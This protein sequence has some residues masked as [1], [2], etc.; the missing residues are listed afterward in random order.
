M[1]KKI[2]HIMKIKGISG[3]E[4]HLM[5]LLPCLSKYYDVSMVML[6]EN[7]FVFDFRPEVPVTRV[8]IKSHYD[9]SVIWRLY[10]V[11][12]GLKPDIVHTHLIHADLYGT[13][14]AKLAGVKHIVSTKHGYDNYDNTPWLY[15]LNGILSRWV[16]KVITISH[17]LKQKVYDA[18][19]IPK[20]KM[21]TVYYGYDAKNNVPD[22]PTKSICSYTIGSIG[23]MV[24]VK[25]YEY[26]IK[27]MAKCKLDFKLVIIGGGTLK[28]RIY[29]DK[30]ANLAY[31][32]GIYEKIKFE[33]YVENIKPYLF[34][35]DIFV[36]PTL[37]EGFGLVLL[38]A[39]DYSLPIVATN[40]M[41]IPE[42]VGHGTSGLLVPPKDPDALREAI[43]TL[44][45]DPAKRKTMGRNGNKILRYKFPV[46]K[47]VEGTRKVYD[48]LK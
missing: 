2:V 46:S 36:L 14:A 12:K 21:T 24:P 11:L 9:L 45:K 20:S 6:I 40:T 5:T 32:L 19:G 31:D 15:K 28:Q 10:W 35:F 13:V 1:N 27:G 30:L 33:G 42:I 38:E 4:K 23:R 25:G 16:D 47:M 22:I 3:A 37:G 26:L 39:M 41:A 29:E 18:E 48:D 17:A 7:D 8:K 34:R 43:E 44:I